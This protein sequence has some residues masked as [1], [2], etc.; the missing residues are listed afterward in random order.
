MELVLREKG[1]RGNGRREKEKD[2]L[3]NLLKR[4]RGMKREVV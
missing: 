1:E 4:E 3:C 2:I